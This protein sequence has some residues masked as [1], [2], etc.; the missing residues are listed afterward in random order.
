M[1]NDLNF[2][3]IFF[4]YGLAFFSM[5]LLVMMEGGRASDPRLRK[6]LDM[7]AADGFV[8]K[9]NQVGTITEAMDA[10][11]FA[12]QHGMIAVPSGRSITSW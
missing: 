10:Y 2:I 3:L 9:P 7:H 11:L 6:A 1:P 12:Q 5:G 8:L 4:F